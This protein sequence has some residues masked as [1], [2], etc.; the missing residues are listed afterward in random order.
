MTSDP[1]D[2]PYDAASGGTWLTKAELARV[3]RITVASADRLIRRQGWRRQPGNDGRVR[4]LVPSDWQ[5]PERASDRTDPT[6]QEPTDPAHPTDGPTDAD[7]FAAFD[8]AIDAIR[9]AHDGELTAVHLQLFETKFAVDRE[10]DRAD[11]AEQTAAEATARLVRLGETLAAMTRDLEAARNDRTAAVR[12]ADTLHEGLA[13]A[14][15]LATELRAAA[16][17]AEIA[18]A[19]AEA[20]AAEARTAREAAL[21]QAEVVGMRAEANRGV[22]EQLEQELAVAQHD[23]Q[24]AQQAAAQLRLA[25]TARKGRGRLARLRDAWRGR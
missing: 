18:R 5:V 17:A 25:E 14:E 10:R 4:V 19:E 11:R 1:T 7:A 9:K 3:R 22:V 16:E 8:R 2:A 21:R 20:D 24:A 6:D 23:A 15:A 12:R 13:A